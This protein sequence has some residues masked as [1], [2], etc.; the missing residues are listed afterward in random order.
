MKKFLPGAG[1]KD[2]NK[3]FRRMGWIRKQKTIKLILDRYLKVNPMILGL[4]RPSLS[5]I[6]RV[7]RKNTVFDL[8]DHLL[9]F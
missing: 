3:F 4:T 9:F 8:F 5:E 7:S 1:G 2:L 6:F